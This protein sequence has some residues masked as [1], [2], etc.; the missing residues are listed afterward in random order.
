MA[1]RSIEG[2]EP[3]GIARAL[4]ASYRAVPKDLVGRLFEA[5]G[6][7]P[8]ERKFEQ[9]LLYP[10]SGDYVHRTISARAMF[11]LSV[12]RAAIAYALE[13]ER[14]TRPSAAQMAKEFEAIESAALRLLRALRAGSDGDLDKVPYALRYEGLQAWA[15]AEHDKGQSIEFL[16]KEPLGAT[17]VRIA[18][19]GVAAIRRWAR[20]ARE[21]KELSMHEQKVREEN[22]PSAKH[23]GNAAL[24]EFL[25]RVFADCWCAIAGRRVT[26]SPQTIAFCQLAARAVGINLS[27]VAARE[28]IRVIDGRRGKSKRV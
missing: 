20:S 10:K 6:P 4:D 21:R 7:V 26:I 18:I 27:D 25:G 9:A 28:R 22:A 11:I 17:R 2:Y 13:T 1:K 12:E 14:R 19:Q 8:P 15:A 16:P 24:N 3:V 5:M 23:D